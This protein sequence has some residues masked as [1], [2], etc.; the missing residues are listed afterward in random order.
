MHINNALTRMHLH[1]K[2]LIAPVATFRCSADQ[3]AGPQILL[4]SSAVWDLCLNL[5]VCNL[6]LSSLANPAESSQSS[7]GTTQN[8]PPRQEVKIGFNDI[9][10]QT[11]VIRPTFQ[12]NKPPVYTELNCLFPLFPILVSPQ[13]ILNLSFFLPK[14]FLPLHPLMSVLPPP[15]NESVGICLVGYTEDHGL[16]V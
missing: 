7:N 9:I 4:L 3:A 12:S 11:T 1:M 16:M 14:T 13:S 2:K 5:E 15:V 10:G 6:T 8:S